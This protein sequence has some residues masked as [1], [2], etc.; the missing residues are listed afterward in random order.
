M[1]GFGRVSRPRA[2]GA[3]RSASASAG[4]PE[5]LDRLRRGSASTPT[6]HGLVGNA[7]VPQ[8]HD[9]AE[10]PVGRR[11]RRRRVPQIDRHAGRRR[12]RH[13][14][15]RRCQACS[16]HRRH[17]ARRRVPV[18]LTA[19][20]RGDVPP[21]GP[22]R[23][24]PQ[25]T[26]TRIDALDEAAAEDVRRAARRRAARPGAARPRPRP[27]RQ[28]PAPAGVDA[29]RRTSRTS[30]AGS[31]CSATSPPLDGA[32]GWSFT[33]QQRRRQQDRHLPRSA[34]PATTSTHR[35]RDRRDDGRAARRAD[36]HRAGR[37][38]CPTTSSA[39]PVDL[40]RRHQ[41][42]VR[43]VLQPAP[44]VGSD[45]A[46]FAADDVGGREA[47]W[48]VYSQYVDIASRRHERHDRGPRERPP[49]EPR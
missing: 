19:D 10:L 5:F 33:R 7:V 20:E 36:E 35:S 27:A 17:P 24:R 3:G 48:N 45:L 46:G 25:T 16:V 12:H 28:R 37:A 1:T 4:P 15:V 47:G 21:Q 40:P 14:P 49:P 41:P 23:G 6:A 9:D 30:C 22:V 18:E 29:D 26:P 34:R 32:D 31:T 38:A 13:G 44:A 43:V 2:P 8:P 42:P 11:G 39:T